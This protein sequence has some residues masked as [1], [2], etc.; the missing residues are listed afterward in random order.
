MKDQFKDY[1]KVGLVFGGIFALV[2]LGY[3]H[4][5]YHFLYQEPMVYHISTFI[6]Y[7]V[8]MV[9][10]LS[11]GI[12]LRRKNGAAGI[13]SRQIFQAL[14]MIILCTE[15][16]YFGYSYI[17]L[18]H[19]N[20]GF[21]LEF[22]EIIKEYQL[23]LGMPQEDVEE[24]VEGVIADLE[25]SNSLRYHMR[26]VF[27]WIVIDSIVAILMSLFLKKQPSVNN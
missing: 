13:G 8:F 9:V 25:E 3:L 23:S 2:Y 6:S 12:Y 22:L 11:C 1:W 20:P 10:L 15:I 24:A 27:I 21:Q 5:K 16:A 18:V 4:I 17:Y 7:L 19:V 26:G 14:F